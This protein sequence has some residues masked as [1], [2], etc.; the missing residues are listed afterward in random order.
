MGKKSRTKGKVGEREVVALLKPVF[1]EAERSYHQSH[2]GS[3]ASDIIGTP[4]WIECEMSAAPSP[5]RKMRQALDVL[6]A[7]PADEADLALTTPVVF[8]RQSKR[9]KSGPWLVTMLHGDW[10]AREQRLAQYEQA[11]LERARRLMG[12]AAEVIPVGA[13]V[14][15]DPETGRVRAAGG[16]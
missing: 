4:Y 7:P 15:I 5:H 9:G 11:A 16:L 13:Y 10:L 2:V 12:V 8:T 6:N 3:D 1:P 14:E